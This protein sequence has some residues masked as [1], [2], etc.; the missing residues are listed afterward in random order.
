LATKTGCP[1]STG[2]LEDFADIVILAENSPIFPSLRGGDAATILPMESFELEAALKGIFD[3]KVDLANLRGM[4][5]CLGK[6]TRHRA[7]S[8]E[9]KRRNSET[10]KTY[11]VNTVLLVRIFGTVVMVL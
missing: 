5:T 7:S 2:T 8:V 9:V 10:L 6:I 3:L 4:N 11:P 1:K